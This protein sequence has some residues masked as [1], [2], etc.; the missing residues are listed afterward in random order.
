MMTDTQKAIWQ[1][2]LAER[3]RQD[4][5]HGAMPRNFKPDVYLAVL[6]EEVGE[7]ARALKK[8]DGLNYEEELIQVVAVAVAALEDYFEGE[9]LKDLGGVCGEIE[10]RGGSKKIEE[11]KTNNIDKL[12]SFLDEIGIQFTC[13][14]GT[15]ASCDESVANHNGVLSIN[16]AFGDNYAAVGRILE[17]VAIFALL[18]SHLKP[19][20]SIEKLLP[21]PNVEVDAWTYAA[22]MYMGLP[23]Q[24][25]RGSMANILELRKK[26]H[27]GIKA[28]V[29]HGYTDRLSY[30]KMHRWLAP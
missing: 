19:F 2:I 24:L 27:P 22:C 26:S 11:K 9:A 17:R 23:D 30:P 18:P 6:V 3:D 1:M 13:Y 7:V 29:L 4:E 5:K 16:K 28:L 8:K 20:V 10:Y 14:E 15:G 25:V 21:L 12:L